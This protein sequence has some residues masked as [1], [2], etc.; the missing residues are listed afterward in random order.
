MTRM[1]AHN[2]DTLSGGCLVIDFASRQ[3]AAR[4]SSPENLTAIAHD[5]VDRIAAARPDLSHEAHCSIAKRVVS[6]SISYAAA[7]EP[8]R[9]PLDIPPDDP[10]YAL[11]DAHKEARDKYQRRIAEIAR[12]SG[13]SVKST[14]SR[15]IALRRGQGE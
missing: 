2:P 11:F 3:T 7:T 15:M 1:T 14:A 6:R 4:K 13:R 10:V 8:P 12:R 5:L 9:R